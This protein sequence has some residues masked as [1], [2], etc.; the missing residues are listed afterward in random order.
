MKYSFF[1]FL[2]MPQCKHSL[3]CSRVKCL[4]PWQQCELHQPLPN[5]FPLWLHLFLSKMVL[6]PEARSVTLL[7]ILT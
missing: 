2:C 5:S 7:E 4:F 3:Q 6:R 1:L